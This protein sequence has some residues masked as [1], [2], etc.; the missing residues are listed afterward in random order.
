MCAPK[1]PPP[2]AAPHPPPLSD[3][4]VCGCGAPARPPL[5]PGTPTLSAPALLLHCLARYN[6]THTHTRTHAH[7]LTH[8]PDGGVL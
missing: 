3:A 5:R 1:R 6:V 2:A 4:V 8:R 7:C